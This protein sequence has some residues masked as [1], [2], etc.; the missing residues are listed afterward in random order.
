MRARVPNRL[1][2]AALAGAAIALTLGARLLAP[3]SEAPMPSGAIAV[4]DGATFSEHDLARHLGQPPSF[5]SI[6][7][8]RRAVRELV[9][10]V[11]L[12]E[13]ALR[14]GRP[15]LSDAELLAIL[16]DPRGASIVEEAEIA[17]WYDAH[18][19]KF[20]RPRRIRFAYWSVP[21]GPLPAEDWQ[22]IRA[23]HVQVQMN[24]RPAAFRQLLDRREVGIGVG[25]LGPI[26]CREAGATAVPPAVVE[27]A[28]AG[29]RAEIRARIARERELA[30]RETAMEQLRAD[31]DIRISEHALAAL[32]VP[33]VPQPETTGPPRVPG[34]EA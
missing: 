8:A 20:V 30:T 10:H 24:Q 15:E 13:E 14:R 27:A 19:E 7:A 29:A 2:L 22:R 12:R 17:A 3:G 26:G 21:L 6:D 34:Q 32:R 1:T 31:A 25:E 23:L 18:R 4:I 33:F 5:E 16:A 11:L 28:C 9:D